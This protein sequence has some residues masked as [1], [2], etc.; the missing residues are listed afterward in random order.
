MSTKSYQAA[1]TSLT[2]RT[3][4]LLC[5]TECFHFAAYIFLAASS[6]TSLGLPCL[7]LDRVLKLLPVTNQL[8]FLSTPLETSLSAGPFFSPA[9]VCSLRYY[10]LWLLFHFNFNSTMTTATHKIG[11]LRIAT[12]NSNGMR[13]PPKRRA[14]FANLG[15]MKADFHMIQETHSTENEE[16]IWRTDWGGNAIFSHG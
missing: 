10:L 9:F 3:V 8:V 1:W 2:A 15:K 4:F 14:I 12:L 7:P 16:K 6:Q 5:T 13:S 11:E